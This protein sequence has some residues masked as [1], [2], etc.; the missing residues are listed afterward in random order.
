MRKAI[1][2]E[3]LNLNP[4]AFCVSGRVAQFGASALESRP[5]VTG[6]PG[7]LE[8]VPFAKGKVAG[9]SPATPTILKPALL[10]ALTAGKALTSGLRQRQGCYAH[11]HSDANA[12]R[13]QRH[14]MDNGREQR[15]AM[16]AA[17]MRLNRRGNT[18]VVPSQTRSGATYSV[19]PGETP[20]TLSRPLR[21]FGIYSPYF[22][23][24]VVRFASTG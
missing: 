16:I 20:K 15:G 13:K 6:E 23:H 18:R 17:T 10:A 9:S 19:V 2:F 11:C 3:S 22:Q 4:M 12:R 24:L 8:S 21:R 14:R 1:G 7:S 5:T